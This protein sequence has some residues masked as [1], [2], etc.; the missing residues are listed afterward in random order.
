MQNGNKSGNIFND[1]PWSL[2]MCFVLYIFGI[3]P[4]IHVTRNLNLVSKK[5][6]QTPTLR[7]DLPVRTRS[8]ELGMSLV[9]NRSFSPSCWAGTL[10]CEA[11]HRVVKIMK[12]LITFAVTTTASDPHH[13]AP[14]AW[15]ARHPQA[16]TTYPDTLDRHPVGSVSAQ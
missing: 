1:V 11:P 8:L 3:A 14:E 15:S 5:C 4:S 10:C 6:M 2:R 16:R 13:P 9:W 7:Q 12:S